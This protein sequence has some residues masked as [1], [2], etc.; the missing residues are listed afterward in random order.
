[1]K[2]MTILN[3]LS[4]LSVGDLQELQTA[5]LGEIQH[6]KELSGSATAAAHGSTAG[7]KSSAA[8]HPT[9]APKTARPVG[10]RRAA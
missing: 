2:I 3:R 5:I 4:D 9:A 1:M 10:P 8:G 6:R 7:A